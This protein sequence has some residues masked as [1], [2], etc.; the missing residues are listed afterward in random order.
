M[1]RW[2]RLGRVRTVVLRLME[3]GGLSLI[4]V[5]RAWEGDLDWGVSLG[6]QSVVNDSLLSCGLRGG[7]NGGN[8]VAGRR[9]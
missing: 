1:A 7:F 4:A 5:L 2:S 6:L 8:G 9:L 3:A